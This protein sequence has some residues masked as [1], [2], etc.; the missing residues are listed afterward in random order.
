MRSLRFLTVALAAAV[1]AS[2]GWAVPASAN[3]SEGYIQGAGAVTD[4][5]DDE[6][7]LSTTQNSVGGAVWLWQDIL[8]IEGF[9]NKS[10]VDCQF[11]PKTKA[12]TISWQHAYGVSPFD[13]IVG[14]KTFARAGKN[15][16][17]SGNWVT[18]H[19]IYNTDE[20]W[21]RDPATHRYLKFN[22]YPMKYGPIANCGY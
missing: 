22:T 20:D 12:A 9:L 17:I 6:G 15:L 8:Y 2:A 13:G 4:D 10:D 21:Y 3:V 18:Y 16:T 1:V 19:S 14:P 7:T 11:G 5:F